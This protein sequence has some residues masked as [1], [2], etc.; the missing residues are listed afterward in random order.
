MHLNARLTM[1]RH[2]WQAI[3]SSNHSMFCSDSFDDHT[4]NRLLDLHPDLLADK[5]AD[6][7]MDELNVAR[8]MHLVIKQSVVVCIKQNISRGHVFFKE[9]RL[10]VPDDLR[11]VCTAMHDSATLA[12]RPSSNMVGKNAMLH[13][14]IDSSLNDE[15]FLVIAVDIERGFVFCD[16]TPPSASNFPEEQHHICIP[17]MNVSQVSGVSSLLDAPN[18]KDAMSASPC[19]R[20]ATIYGLRPRC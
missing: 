1:R 10:K 18:F 17:F 13:G 3:M 5:L 2:V 19:L 8:D 15:P 12:R 6:R 4:F 11:Q 7:I 14:M 9:G 16:A 20:G